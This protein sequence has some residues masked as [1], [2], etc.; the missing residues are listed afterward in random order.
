MYTFFVGTFWKMS[1]YKYDQMFT[2]ILWYGVYSITLVLL[3]IVDAQI[4][5]LSYIFI[6]C[7]IFCHFLIC[8]IL[9]WLKIWDLYCTNH[10][11]NTCNPAGNRHLLQL[12]HTTPPFTDNNTNIL[13]YGSAFSINIKESTKQ[14]VAIH[15]KIQK[16]SSKN[17]G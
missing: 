13:T 7:Y 9:T 2:N 5:I 14:P 12:Q 6:D 10:T 16:T 15:K 1:I 11:R 17:R 8:W 3:C 4:L